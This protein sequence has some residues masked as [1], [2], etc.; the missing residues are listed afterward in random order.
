MPATRFLGTLLALLPLLS[1]ADVSVPDTP[2]GRALGA[3]LDAFNSGEPARVESFIKTHASGMNSD[4]IVKW[5]AETGRYDLLEI[6]PNDPA[7]VFFRIKA[8]ANAVEEVGRLTMSVTDPGTVADFAT[9]R[10]PAGAKVDVVA[11]DA[12]ARAE[13]IG[14]VAGL[15]DE[16]YVFPEV[17]KKMTAALRKHG[18]R[19]DY[20]S[21]RYGQDL[22]RKLTE[23]LREISRDKHAEVRFSFVVQ[24]PEGTP[25]KDPAK[26]ARRLAA[27][28]CGFKKAEQL[29][30]NIGYLKLDGFAD[31]EVCA[32]TASAAMT[33]LADSD[34]LIL[35]L[36]DNRGG[37]G[38]MTEFIASYLF[39]ERTR[40]NDVFWRA[41]NATQESWTLPYVPGKKFIGKPVYVLTSK[42][43][44]SAAESLSYA[45]KNLKRA[46]LVGES[47]GGGAHPIDMK[48][49][50][51][52]F[53]L[54]VPTGRSI[55][56]ITKTNWQGTG[57]E[58]DVNVSA[59][60][61]LDVARKLASEEIGK[62]RGRVSSIRVFCGEPASDLQACSRRRA[63][64]NA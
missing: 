7:T 16:F 44:F 64:T 45:L 57:V 56:P 50:D 58:P 33:F 17:A 41:E 51:D 43:T 22:A 55:S 8:Q 36:R 29:P 10:I 49:V 61:A 26:E 38:A 5:Q 35:D 28:N 25:N 62:V 42:Q 4:W 52:H 54:I 1:L 13:L 39:A 18:R 34:A 53:M 60:E 20:D 23:D 2:A 37:M 46:T 59:A 24:P 47:T 11:P 32:L 19:G 9:W 48:R 31:T 12:K 27:I 30:S 21:I 63:G 14:R 40:L 15:I 3:W 6:Y